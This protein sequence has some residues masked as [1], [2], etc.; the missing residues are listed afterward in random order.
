MCF[1]STNVLQQAWQVI[2]VCGAESYVDD[3][4]I[5]LSFPLKDIEESLCQVKQDLHRVAEWCCSNHLLVNPGKT[6]FVL[7]GVRQILSKVPNVTV[8]FL[9]QNLTPTTSCKDLGVILDSS[10]SFNEHINYVK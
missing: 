1:L 6:E 5:Y 7:F 4:K 8:L 3:T 2:R 10:L 9:G